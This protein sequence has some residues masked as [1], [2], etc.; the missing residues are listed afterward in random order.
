MYLFN[1]AFAY[2]KK[3]KAKTILL[4]V[5]FFIIANI[6]LAGLSIQSATETAKVLT[7]QEIGADVIYTFNT[8]KLTTDFKSGVIDATVDRSTLEGAP[9]YGNFIKL[10]DSDMI[11]SYDAVSNYEVT[12][13]VLTPY[14]YVSS[15]STSTTGTGSGQGAGKLITGTYESSGD[16]SLRTFTRTEPSDFVDGTSSLLQGRYATQSEIDEGAYVVLIEKTLA[17]LNQIKLGDSL[18]LTPTVEAYNTS[19]LTYEVIGI[20]QTNE[21]IDDRS[22]SMVGSSLLAQNRLYTPFTT[23][24]AMGYTDNELSQV[25]LD[26]AVITLDDPLNVDAYLASIEGEIN[27]VYGSISANDAVYEQ[28]AGPIDTLGQMSTVLVWIVVIAGA[29][30]LSL[31]TALTINQRRNEIGILLAIGESKTKIVSQFIVEVLTIAIIAFTLSTFSGLKIG[32]M[33]SETTLSTFLTPEQTEVVPTGVGRR[34]STVSIEDIEP[35][36]LN[37]K[38]DPI[39]LIQFFGAGLLIS[40]ISVAIPALYVTRFNPKQILTN[41]G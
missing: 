34:A 1:R 29:A 28:L 27:L 3:Q 4:L 6:V 21:I 5:L 37:V 8:S 35:V 10:L 40:I 39:V 20:Y 19:T 30:I 13:E 24:S 14:V 33:I 31:I 26:K 15:T 12:T 9:L 2:I 32:Q 25:L 23:L 11:Q 36:E 17:D 38:F 18:S 7:R 16:L 41:N 22:A